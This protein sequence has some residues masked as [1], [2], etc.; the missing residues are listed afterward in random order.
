MNRFLCFIVVFF[1]LE[2]CSKGY[3]HK[4]TAENLNV[5][6]EKKDL[7]KLANSLGKFWQEKEL[8]GEREQNIKLSENKESY[9]IHLIISEEFKDAELTFEER[10]LLFELQKEMDTT[11]FKSLKPCKILICDNEF[12]T[13]YSIDY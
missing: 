11:I 10:K 4:L 2:S 6:F 5:Y 1:F 12:K 13:L 7:E 3:G 8:V 9:F